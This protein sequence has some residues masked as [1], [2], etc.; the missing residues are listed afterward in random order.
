M[1]RKVERRRW[2]VTLGG[3]PDMGPGVPVS[4][5]VPTTAIVSATTERH[6]AHYLPLPLQP[7][8]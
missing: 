6:C 4:S 8:R 5:R 3:V 1:V 2:V 7:P